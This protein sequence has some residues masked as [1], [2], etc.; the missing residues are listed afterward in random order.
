M[1]RS[2]SYRHRCHQR[3]LLIRP[4]RK[5]CRLQSVQRDKLQ[6]QVQSFSDVA[7]MS[8]SQLLRSVVRPGPG[9]VR[10]HFDNQASATF[11]DAHHNAAPFFCNLEV[12]HHPYAASLPP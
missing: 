2:G 7:T 5:R 6:A 4:Q 3:G 8:A 11:E 9:F 1:S 12:G 10:R